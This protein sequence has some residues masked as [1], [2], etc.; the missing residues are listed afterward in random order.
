MSVFAS[1]LEYLRGKRAYFNA[2]ASQFYYHHGRL[3]ASHP[4]SLLVLCFFF[5]VFCSYPVL[6]D[7]WKYLNSLSGNFEPSQFWEIPSLRAPIEE[8]LFIEKFGTEPFL[9]LEQVMINAST[10]NAMYRNGRGG[11]VLDRDLFARVIELQN[12]I[13]NITVELSSTSTVL[14]DGHAYHRTS[15]P[16]KDSP[17]RFTV[18]DICFKPFADNRCLIHTPLDFWNGRL[19]ELLNDS[20]IRETL[21]HS[22]GLSSFGIPIPLQSVFGG[23]V[24]ESSSGKIISA[25]SI[26]ITYFLEDKKDFPKELTLQI[27]GAIWEKVGRTF[28]EQDFKSLS[29][30][31]TTGEVKHL[32]YEVRGGAPAVFAI[33]PTDGLAG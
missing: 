23:A 30:K 28:N 16:E 19:P 2:Q 7:W 1:M 18:K 5:I 20:D 33:K 26:V 32:Y 9:R 31:R 17:E 6:E 24:F 11:G 12:A 29:V 4:I 27:W 3:C 13:S 22:Q 21:S 14:D 10:T 15:M 8:A 25:N